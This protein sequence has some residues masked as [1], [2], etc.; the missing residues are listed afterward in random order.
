[1]KNVDIVLLR[2]GFSTK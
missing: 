1:M 2:R